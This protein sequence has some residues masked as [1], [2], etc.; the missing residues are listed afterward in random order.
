MGKKKG[1]MD[2]VWKGDISPQPMSTR[3]A[4]YSVCLSRR[5]SSQEL[6]AQI[7]KPCGQRS[8]PQGSLSPCEVLPTILRTGSICLPG[9][10]SNGYTPG[11]LLSVQLLPLKH[12]PTQNSSYSWCLYTPD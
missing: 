6:T 10:L 8:H 9:L 3:E 5:H 7:H 12:R 2:S 1:T 11:W 4:P